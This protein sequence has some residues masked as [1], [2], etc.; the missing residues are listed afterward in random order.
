MGQTGSTFIYLHCIMTVCHIYK[1]DLYRAHPCELQKKSDQTSIDLQADDC[2]IYNDLMMTS[3]C[4]YLPE[5]ETD[6]L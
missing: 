6:M 1:T 2:T 3:G 5:G 4:S